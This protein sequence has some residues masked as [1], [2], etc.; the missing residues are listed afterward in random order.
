MFAKGGGAEVEAVQIEDAPLVGHRSLM[1][2]SLS[3]APSLPPRPLSRSISDWTARQV[4]CARE[5]LSLAF[6]L[7]TIKKLSS[8]KMSVSRPACSSFSLPPSFLC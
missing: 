2:L 4:D 1:V 6:H 7:S 5:H 8:I 3:L